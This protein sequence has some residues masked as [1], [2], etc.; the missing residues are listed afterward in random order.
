[1]FALK[2]QSADRGN[3]SYLYATAACAEGICVHPTSPQT[4][5]VSHTRL[6][7][8]EKTGRSGKYNPSG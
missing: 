2:L 5:L 7:V 4:A 1:M 3:Q 6:S 8:M